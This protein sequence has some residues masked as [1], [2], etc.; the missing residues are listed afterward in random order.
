[1]LRFMW[2]CF[3]LGTSLGAGICVAILLLACL[4]SK[5]KKK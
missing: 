3:V 1:M 2:E 4:F 5:S